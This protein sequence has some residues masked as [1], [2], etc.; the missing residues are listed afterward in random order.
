[1]GPNIEVRTALERRV[2]IAPPEL[3]KTE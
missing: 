2:G 3:S 1:V